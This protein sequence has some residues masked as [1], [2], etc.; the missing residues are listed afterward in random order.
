MS[1]PNRKAPFRSVDSPQGWVVFQKEQ[2]K[3][4][5]AWTATQTAEGADAQSLVSGGKVQKEIPSHWIALPTGIDLQVHLRHPGQSQKETLIGGLESAL[6]GGYDS[7][8]TMPNTNPFLDNPEVLAEAIASCR[9]AAADYPVRVGF[10]ASATKGM[11]G[12]DPTDIG[13]LA[14]AGAVAVTDDG[15]GVKSAEAQA[16]VFDQCRANDLLF[17]QHAETHGHKGVAPESDFQRRH[18]LPP[19]PRDAESSMVARDIE[20]LRKVPGARYHILHISTRETLREIR[21]AKSEGLSVTAEVCPHHLFF[22]SADI[23]EDY[24]STYFKMNP[25]LFGPEDRAA[26]REALRDGTID[27]VSTDHAPHEKE[28]KGKGWLLAPFGTRGMETALSTL[29]SLVATNELS[30]ARLVE[31]FSSS[32]RKIL[33]RTEFAQS[34]GRLFVDPRKKFTVGME[35]LPGI[36][37][38]SCFLGASLHGRIELRAERGRL[39]ERT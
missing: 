12:Q 7:V 39:Y 1:P 24:R 37:E 36:S 27:C 31:V 16:S 29:L 38:N 17:Q 3:V 22:S 23:P 19:Y 6:Y 15:W 28:M 18:Q 30:M 14:R 26:L 13:A 21:L 20:L 34:T 8:V 2:G 4:V 5:R 9:E 11:Q 32:P 25:P 10:T 35:D 33:N